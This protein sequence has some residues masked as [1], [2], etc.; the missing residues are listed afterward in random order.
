M[1]DDVRLPTCHFKGWGHYHEDY[2]KEDG[3]WKLKK[4][5]LT[6]PAYRG[7]MGV[8]KDN[9]VVLRAIDDSAR[10]MQI[11]QRG[12]RTQRSPRCVCVSS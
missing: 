1:F 11:I 8:A 5:H 3:Q 2:V 9:R 12:S 10:S 6:P 7:R 4:I